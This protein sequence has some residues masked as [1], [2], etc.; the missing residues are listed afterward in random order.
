M[1]VPVQDGLAVGA[2]V[3][4]GTQMNAP[5]VPDFGALPRRFGAAAQQAGDMAARLAD[6]V[7]KTI[8]GEALAKLQDAAD[9]RRLDPETGFASLLGRSEK[10]AAT[11]NFCPGGAGCPSGLYAA[12]FGPYADAGAQGGRREFGKS[13]GFE[14]EGV[15]VGFRRG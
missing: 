3:L 6:E 5:S 10:R 8:A 1:K 4:P 12:G 14:F 9:R 15:S 2:D 13:V 7:N 11:G